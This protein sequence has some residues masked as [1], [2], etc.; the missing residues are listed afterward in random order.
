VI[1]GPDTVIVLDGASHP[2]PGSRDGGWYA[3]TLGRARHPLVPKPDLDLTKALARAIH[4]VATRHDPRPGA[5][6]SS[7]VSIVRWDT[8]RV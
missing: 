5:A 1:I 4:A 3:E 6:P 2:E 7:T 8:T